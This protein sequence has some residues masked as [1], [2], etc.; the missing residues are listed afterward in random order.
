[1]RAYKYGGPELRDLNRQFVHQPS[2]GIPEEQQVTDYIAA[3]EDIR[4]KVLAAETIG[5]AYVEMKVS[6]APEKP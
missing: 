2:L 1:M 5:L 4:K 3:A 6:D